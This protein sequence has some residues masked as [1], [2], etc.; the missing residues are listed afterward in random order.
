[1]KNFFIAVL[2]VVLSLQTYQAYAG[3]I[4]PKHAEIEKEF[5]NIID[6]KIED[7]FRIS[8]NLNSGSR[9]RCR[10]V[11]Q[12]WVYLR[13][14]KD[15]IATVFEIYPTGVCKF[16]DYRYKGKGGMELIPSEY[17]DEVNEMLAFIE[18]KQLEKYNQLKTKRLAENGRRYFWIA[19]YWYIE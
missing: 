7:S 18:E 12:R 14:L 5:V 8:F 4:S 1:M 13:I 9:T 3:I 16:V 19:Y 2:L 17:L 11:N 6:R 10:T 15:D